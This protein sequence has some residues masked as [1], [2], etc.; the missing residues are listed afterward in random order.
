VVRPAEAN[1]IDRLAELWCA[2][3]HEAHAPIVPAELTQLR[4][5]A[6]FRDRLTAA[7]ENTRVAGP[8]GTPR[9]FY[10]LKGDELYQFFVAPD[11]RGSGLAATLMADAEARLS[12]A[13]VSTAWLS[14]AIGNN[15]AARFYEKCGWR[16]VGTMLN[17]LETSAGTF[18]L[19]VWRYEK[20]LLRGFE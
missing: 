14:C 15:R 6:S 8:A 13:G 16:R 9:G 12:D 5:L 10:V 18:V 11:A 2:G 4:T 3:W 19:Q 1:E 17:E 20:D 7:L